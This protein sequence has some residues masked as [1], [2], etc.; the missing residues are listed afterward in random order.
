ME[1]VARALS[2]AASFQRMR[3]VDR[4]RLTRHR[5]GRTGH[6]GNALAWW[7][8]G[9]RRRGIGLRVRNRRSSRSASVGVGDDGVTLCRT[10]P[11]RRC[12]H[13]GGVPQRHRRAHPR[14]APRHRTP[15]PARPRQS[16][17]PA[18]GLTSKGC[19]G[20]ATQSAASSRSKRSRPSGPRARAR[21]CQ[22]RRSK[23]APAAAR[24][25]S[26]PASQDRSPSL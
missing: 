12:R 8:A 23:D 16:R 4:V 19:Q 25:A 18:A 3:L 22:E 17:R 9:D 5:P 7:Q 26:R 6:F 20:S 11:D 13:V 14:P 10:C 15:R 21:A 1:H 2:H 24:A